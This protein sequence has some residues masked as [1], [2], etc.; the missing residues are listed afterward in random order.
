MQASYLKQLPDSKLLMLV[1]L[2]QLLVRL[3]LLSEGY[4]I[5]E[6]SYGHVLHTQELHQTGVYSISR[7]PGH[8]VYEGMLYALSFFSDAPL[9]FN[10]LSVLFGLLGLFWF[11]KIYVFYRLPYPL[12]ATT[13]LGLLPVYYITST[14]TIDYVIA[15]AL[16]LATY[17]ALLRNKWPLAALLLGL[18]AGVRLTALAMGLPFFLILWD[19]SFQRAKIFRA[20]GFGLMAF[21]VTTI[22]YLPPY[23]AMGWSFFDTYIL[24]WPPVPKILYKASIGAFGVLGVLGLICSFGPSVWERLMGRKV[25]GT[26]VPAVHAFAWVMVL[27]IY[28]GLYIRVP[29]KSAFVLPMLPFIFLYAAFWMPQQ[30]LKIMYMFFIPASFVMGINLTDASRGADCSVFSKN[31]VLANQEICLDPLQGPIFHESSKRKNKAA[32]TQQLIAASQNLPDSAVI[33]AGWWQGM[34]L[35]ALRN[36]NPRPDLVWAYYLPEVTFTSYLKA[37]RP[38]YF[39]AEQ[40]VINNRKYNNQLATQHAML[41]DVAP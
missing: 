29:E 11:Y 23:F 15:L 38:I 36:E 35:V 1:L 18:A 33:I 25:F 24:P 26:D 9:V 12:L 2:L 20:M 19:F 17:L 21:L 31:L 27:L 14:Y 40:E 37:N 10:G 22:C 32:Y 8:P 3:P 7:L 28:T 4:G 16:V 13:A 39:L 5:E 30:R 41:W 34:V 6:D